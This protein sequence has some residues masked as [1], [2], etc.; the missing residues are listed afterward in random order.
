MGGSWGSGEE[1][2]WGWGMG[3]REFGKQRGGP[4]ASPACIRRGWTY[5]AD[6]IIL[7][8]VQTDASLAQTDYLH[9][10]FLLV[11]V[12]G[13]DLPCLWISRSQSVLVVSVYCVSVTGASSLCPIF[14]PAQPSLS[15]L[16]LCSGFPDGRTSLLVFSVAKQDIH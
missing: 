13:S 8:S 2:Y 11:F 7:V 15:L 5:D 4:F 3:A 9:L 6:Q 10:V 16:F 1:G 12:S 14:I